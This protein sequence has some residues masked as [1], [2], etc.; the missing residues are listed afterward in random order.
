MLNGQFWRVNTWGSPE[1]SEKREA[2]TS[3]I[4]TKPCVNARIQCLTTSPLLLSIPPAFY[5]LYPQLSTSDLCSFSLSQ[6]SDW[7]KW[8]HSLIFFLS[9]LRLYHGSEAT[10]GRVTLSRALPPA[11]C[12]AAAALA[13]GRG[14]I[15][16]SEDLSLL[17]S[18]FTESKCHKWNISTFIAFIWLI[19]TGIFLSFL[20]DKLLH[21]KKH[22]PSFFLD[23]FGHA[24]PSIL[25]VTWIYVL[26]L[27]LWIKKT[28]PFP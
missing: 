23:V 27:D 4:A 19:F 12:P 25:C 8:S 15:Q 18:C 5:P 13:A 14:T 6:I 28:K 24:C 21:G 10:Q 9:F 3:L 17:P 2:H 20:E 11:P 7:H 22:V 26:I 16:G 1:A